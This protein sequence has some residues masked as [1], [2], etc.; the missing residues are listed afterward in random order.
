MHATKMQ[1]IKKKNLISMNPFQEALGG[2]VPPTMRQKINKEENMRYKK[3]EI[4]PWRE[5][6]GIPIKRTLSKNPTTEH[7]G[8]PYVEGKQTRTEQYNSKGRQ[9]EAVL[10]NI[11]AVSSFQLEQ[12]S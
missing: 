5:I 7:S 12:K 9:T 2:C 6:N 3:Q 10:K 1:A 11:S 8:I 4:Q